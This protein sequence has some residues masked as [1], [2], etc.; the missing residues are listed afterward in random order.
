MNIPLEDFLQCPA[1]PVDP[2]QIG[3]SAQGILVKEGTPYGRKG[4]WDIFD[5][6]GTNHYPY[7]PDF[8]EEG[9]R[10]GFSRRVP[11]SAPLNLLTTESMHLLAHS[12]AIIKNYKPFYEDRQNIRLCPRGHEIHNSGEAEQS[13]LGLLWE[14][15]DPDLEDQRI[16]RRWFPPKTENQFDYKAA[17]YHE[18]VEWEFGIFAALPIT[19]F[20]V[21][22]DPYSDKAEQAMQ[23]LEESGTDIPYYLVDA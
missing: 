13:C 8:V 16:H 2:N 12:R 10:Y 23:L 1:V 4:I 9:Q 15:L 11:K 20:E 6:V 7:V 19:S 17:H 18:D 21:I 22:D 14:V 3:L 5:W